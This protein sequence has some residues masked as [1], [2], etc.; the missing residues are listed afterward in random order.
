MERLS[1]TVTSETPEEPS[2][3][4]IAPQFVMLWTSPTTATVLV[5]FQENAAYTVVDPHAVS[6][7][8]NV[9]LRYTAHSP[10]G[11]ATASVS[12]RKLVYRFTGLTQREYGFSLKRVASTAAPS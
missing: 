9:S 12:L 11:A 6:I 7:G 2:A 10:S 4:V 3:R 5:Y 8:P 1:C